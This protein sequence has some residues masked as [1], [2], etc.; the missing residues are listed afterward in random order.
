MSEKTLT[1]LIETRQEVWIAMLDARI[2]RAEAAER[3][4]EAWLALG[5]DNISSGTWDAHVQALEAYKDAREAVRKL[6]EQD[7]G[8]KG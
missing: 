1:E 2:R 7:K 4:A 8:G 5:E 3:L 6:E